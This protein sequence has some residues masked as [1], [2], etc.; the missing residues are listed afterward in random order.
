MI[1]F[2]WGSWR[3]VVLGGGGGAFPVLADL[4]E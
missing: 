2:Y 1:A 3:E 4:V